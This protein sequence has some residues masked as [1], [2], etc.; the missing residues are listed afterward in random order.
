MKKA[1]IVGCNGQDGTLLTKLLMQRK[2]VVMG[3]GNT[4]VYINESL[5]T[6]NAINLCDYESVTMLLKSFRPNEV[7]Y[8]AANHGSSEDNS[9]NN[10]LEVYA[11]SHRVHVS[12]IMSF[13]EAIKNHLFHCRIFYASSSYIFGDFNGILQDED[14]PINPQGI[15]GITKA[16]GGMICKEYRKKYGIY[17]SVGILYNH[18]SCL[19]NRNFIS[20][21]IIHQ[22]IEIKSNIRDHLVVGDLDARVDWGYAPDYVDAFTRILKLPSSDDFI[23]STGELHSVRDFV[24]TVAKHLNLNLDGKIIENNKILHKLIRTRVGNSEKLKNHTGWQPS[25]GFAKMVKKIVFDTIDMN[26]LN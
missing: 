23:V 18:E 8:L 26:I 7:Y 12:G 2:Y 1:I 11:E 3:L 24:D 14:T 22:A 5:N 13:L 4:G 17:S 10:F 16:A 15:Y 19:R 9:L 20:S 25:I 6:T 21:K